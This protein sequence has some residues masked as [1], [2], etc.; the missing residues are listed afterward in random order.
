[1]SGKRFG[2]WL[3]LDYA[4]KERW[5]CHCLCGNKKAISRSSLVTGRSKSCGCYKSPPEEEYKER[6][7]KRL[8]KKI[9]INEIGC[10][11]WQGAKSTSG[12]GHTTY[13]KDRCVRAHRASYL[14]WIEEIPN[15]F[16]V[17]H[18][19]DNPICINPEHL[20]LGTHEQ[21]MKDMK[22][23]NRACKGEK[24]HLHASNRGKRK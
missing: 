9:K 23:K 3:V 8:K 4:G 22:N 2:N 12:Y 17:C 24:S 1:M 15:G 16:F 13:R 10:W 20:F 19:C 5:N 21:N 18:K 6:T 11:E 7:K 14:V